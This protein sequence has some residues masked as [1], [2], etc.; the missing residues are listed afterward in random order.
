M[1]ELD[2]NQEEY[3]FVVFFFIA[4]IILTILAICSLGTP[5]PT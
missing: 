5:P 1:S 4:L 2:K 3:N